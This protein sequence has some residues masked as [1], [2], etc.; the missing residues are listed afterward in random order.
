MDGF[1]EGDRVKWTGSRGKSRIAVVTQV[2]RASVFYVCEIPCASCAPDR[3]NSM[4][5]NPHATWQAWGRVERI[6]IAT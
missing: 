6:L 3:Y 5:R 1:K 2:T 4:I